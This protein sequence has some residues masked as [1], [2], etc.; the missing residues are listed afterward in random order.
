MTQD[1]I[2]ILLVE[3]FEMVRSGLKKLLEEDSTIQVAA[4]AM[5]G[6]EAVELFEEVRP[7]VVVMD[8][9][10]PVMDGLDASKAILKAHPNAKILILTMHDEKRFAA[11]LL[12]IGVLG[13][14]TKK[15]DAEALQAAVHSVYQ[16][17]N[18]LS[19]E[20]R[21]TL[22]RQMLKY[23][24]TG[25]DRLSDREIQILTMIARGKRPKEIAADLGI[26]VKTVDNHRAHMME[27]LGLDTNA[28]VVLFAKDQGLT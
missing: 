14:I 16:R 9:T 5:N 28:D 25:I 23:N 13:Y 19:D 6:K 4:E 10:M 11:R 8:I 17:K 21:D 20:A 24:G 15:A 12:R 2:R 7:D 22:L 26:S 18:Y 1:A 3:D 27:K